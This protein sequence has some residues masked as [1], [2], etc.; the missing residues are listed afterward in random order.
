VE[1][2]W[3]DL[4]ASFA[5]DEARLISEWGKSGGLVQTLTYGPN[6]VDSG[7]SAAA[8]RIY[9]PP[10]GDGGPV[11]NILFDTVVT[12]GVGTIPSLA[13]SMLARGAGE[14]IAGSTVRST[15]AVKNGDALLLERGVKDVGL[16]QSILN[17]GFNPA[18]LSDASP[19]TMTRFDKLFQG[20]LD[21]GKAF[22]GRLGNLSTRAR[23]IE[24][25]VKIDRLGLTPN[26]ESMV[27]LESGSA[28]F[29]DVTALNA[30]RDPVRYFQLYRET[31]MG[32]IPL[33]EVNAANDIFSATG[34]RPIMIRTG[35]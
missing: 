5:Q 7:M 29:V 33:R 8:A 30:T 24:Q 13:R 28:R 15:L 1:G 22:R 12:A 16:R 17:T 9:D 27:R 34:I 6:F 11:L 23:T 21:A 19:T 14:A 2:H 4:Q 35:P 3:N 25:A 20:S 10:I 26:F 32:T 31:S 18:I